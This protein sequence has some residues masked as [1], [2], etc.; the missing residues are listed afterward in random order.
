MPPKSFTTNKSSIQSNWRIGLPLTLGAA[1]MWAVLPIMLKGLLTELSPASS[2]FYRFLV[3]AIMLIAIL[4]FRKKPNNLIKLGRPRLLLATLFARCHAGGQLP[5]LC[6]G[7]GSHHTQRIAGTDTTG[8]CY[9]F[10]GQ[11]CAIQRAFFKTAMAWLC[12]LYRRSGAVFP[13]STVSTDHRS[14]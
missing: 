3:A 6:L 5:A 2:A 12:N 1:L 13:P 10:A 7:V 4:A 9:A 14:R 8:P 11:H